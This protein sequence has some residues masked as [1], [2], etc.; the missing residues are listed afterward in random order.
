LPN[1]PKEYEKTAILS[2]GTQVL[3]RPEQTTD[4]EMLWQM[5][6][7]LSERS[8]RFL[9]NRFP[10]ERIE[11]WTSSIN[12]ERALPILAIVEEAGS[13]RVVGVASLEFHD[14]L[15]E[16]HKAE[17]GI[18]VHDSYQNRGLGTA[19]TQHMLAIARKKRLRK[20]TLNVLV[21][22]KRA[23]RMYEKCGFKIEAKLLKESFVKGRYYD[24]YV[25]STFL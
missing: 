20:V 18:T 23:I 1:Y 11:H 2:D 9:V 24:D 12:Y 16:R 22:N 3:F 8:L 4:T 25:M 6:S 13:P 21:G 7:T 15:A 10:R 14:T 5:F 17:F 19:L